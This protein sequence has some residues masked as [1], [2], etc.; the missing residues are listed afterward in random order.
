MAHSSLDSVRGEEGKY[1]KKRRVHFC[2]LLN[3]IILLAKF[4]FYAPPDSGT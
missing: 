1:K 4:N 3:F 2:N